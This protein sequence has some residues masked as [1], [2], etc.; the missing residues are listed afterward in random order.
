MAYNEGMEEPEFEPNVDEE[1]LRVQA[2]RRRRAA[3]LV[4]LL[5]MLLPLVLNLLRWLDGGMGEPVPTRAPT[6]IPELPVDIHF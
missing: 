3:A 1:A 4:L 5:V 2:E 6:W